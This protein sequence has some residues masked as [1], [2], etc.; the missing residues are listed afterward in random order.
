LYDV[1]FWVHIFS[2]SFGSVV[3]KMR[4]GG[5]SVWGE[6]S[7]GRVVWIPDISVAFRCFPHSTWMAF[8]NCR[9]I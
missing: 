9:T 2:G 6:L 3:D 1:K 5:E 4:I 8:H 7:R